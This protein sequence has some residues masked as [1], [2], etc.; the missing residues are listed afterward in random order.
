[1][2]WQKRT[3][4]ARPM[5]APANPDY[6][7]IFRITPG[8]TAEAILLDEPYRIPTHYVREVGTL[9]CLGEGCPHCPDVE[10]LR[11]YGPALKVGP[12]DVETGK[13]HWVKCIVELT[14]ENISRIDRLPARGLKIQL[15]RKPQKKSHTM[16]DVPANQPTDEV[17]PAFDV[18]PILRRLWGIDKPKAPREGVVPFPTRR[19]A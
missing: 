12:L 14:S 11:W 6:I 2:E 19:Q 8:C 16:L 9:P 10:R 18:Q 1:M 13:R 5:D 17:P 4:E 15:S 7:P 3:H